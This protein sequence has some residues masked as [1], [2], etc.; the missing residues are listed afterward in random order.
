MPQ[1]TFLTEFDLHLL[2]QGKHNRSFD[3]LGAHPCK[4]G[5]KRGVH[6]AVW[7]PN[8]E[9][10]AVIGDFNDWQEGMHP[11]SSSD[12]GIWSA[13]IPGASFGDRYKYYISAQGFSAEKADPYAFCSEIRPQ[14]ASVVYDLNQYQWNDA[15]WMSNRRTT[16]AHDRPIS[17]YEVH[18]GSW[19]RV[20]EENHRW[21]TYREVAHELADYVREM[22][23][24]HVELLP[25]CEHP[26]D[27]SWGYQTIGYFAPTSRFGSPDDFRYFVET[28]HQAGI[29]VILDWVPAHFPTDG[30]GLARFDG[31]HLYEHADPR[32]GVHREWGTLVF[33]FG[34]HEVCNFLIASALFWLEKYHID[35]FRVDAVASMLYLDYSRDQG[36]WLPNAYGSRENLE[37]V[38]F[39]KR[40]NAEVYQQPDVLTVAEESTA[41]PMVTQPTYSGGL[42]FGYKWNMGWMHDTLSFISKDPIH[43]TY[44]HN[45]LTFSLLYAFHENFVLPFSHDEVV[46]GKGSMIG[47][48]PGDDWQRFA[49]LRALYGYMFGHPGKKLLFM[50]CEFGQWG[51]WRFDQSLDWH[52]L[53]ELFHSG[54]RLWVKDL[55]NLL[56]KERALYEKDFEPAGFR[57]IDCNDSAQSIL[58][59]IRYGADQSDL[60]LQV[61]NFT[62]VVRE[63]YRLGVPQGGKW[64]EV[65]NSDSEFYGGSG[66]G[67]LGMLEAQPTPFHG[68]ECSLEMQLPPL[69]VLFFKPA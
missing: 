9:Y 60:I 25:I 31:T 42:G 17:I 65:L 55:N 12:A 1:N 50:G 63:G 45:S 26:L 21:L 34:R 40:L 35:G 36:E 30:H 68:F 44:H 56:H 4:I 8:A 14:T 47:K 32:Q 37:A 41:W 39:I 54:L 62:P 2:N 11:M 29:G 33:N 19:R 57:W 13:F 59:F 27:G 16:A 22:G 18:L 15:S 67:N 38:E 3:K 52:L 10:V 43:R 46:H 24:T 28:L 6:F 5:D 69:S 48:M 51:E 53:G 7:A 49:N 66:V 23:F 58:S 61:C 20:P 64:R